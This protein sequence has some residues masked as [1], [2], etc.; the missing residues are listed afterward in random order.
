MG[1]EALLCFF[2]V[3]AFAG[4]TGKEWMARELLMLDGAFRPFEARARSRLKMRFQRETTSIKTVI[5]AQAG[6]QAWPRGLGSAVVSFSWVPAFAGM[7]GKEWMFGEFLIPDG[8]FRPF[9]A[10]ARSHLKMRF[11][12]ETT[13]IK[14]V[15]PAQA[16][17]QARPGGLGSAVVH[18]P[19]SP[20]SRG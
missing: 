19:G 20:P 1:W 9:E 4:V 14:T 12:R 5:P 3:P 13:S 18:F 15:I 8:A 6:T 7:T 2:W 10:R 17:T 11:Q 16:G